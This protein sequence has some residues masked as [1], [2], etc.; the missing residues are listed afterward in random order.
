[1]AGGPVD[2]DRGGDDVDHDR[3]ADLSEGRL[4]CRGLPVGLDDEV[5]VVGPCLHLQRP[6]ALGV[7]VLGARCSALRRTSTSRTR[8]R[9][10][11]PNRVAPPR[12]SS[13]NSFPEAA[14]R[15]VTVAACEMR[16]HDAH[17]TSRASISF[18][19]PALRKVARAWRFAKDSIGAVSVP[20]NRSS[21]SPFFVGTSP[22][23]SP[24]PNACAHSCANR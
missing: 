21:C 6:A 11:I 5:G 16:S 10:P 23:S 7:E 22:Y 19:A 2:D 1:M 9:S 20:S 3:R 17:F 12:T 8:T 24:R 18:G 14:G 15:A 13:R 4:G